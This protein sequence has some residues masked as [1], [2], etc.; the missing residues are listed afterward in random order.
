MSLLFVTG[1]KH[2]FKEAESILKEYGIR[3]DNVSLSVPE[4]RGE[5]C[6]VIAAAAARYAYDKLKR[7]LFTEDSGLF[8]ESLNGFPGPY[9]AW[10]FSKLGNEGILKLMTGTVKR[11]AGFT[12]AVGYAD[13]NGVRTFIVSCPGNMALE[14]R[15]SSGFGYDPIFI[16]EGHVKTFSEDSAMKERVSHRRK[17]LEKLAEWLKKG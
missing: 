11:D 15:G 9:S 8:I 2:K 14:Q 4:E 3:I 12:S 10:V 6:G 13:E 5:D 1:N 16:P 7:P 17:V